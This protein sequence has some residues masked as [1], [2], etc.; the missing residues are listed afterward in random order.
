MEND[1]LVVSDAAALVRLEKS[2]E[3][4][5]KPRLGMSNVEA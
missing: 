2:E 3:S 1:P 4:P 5:S